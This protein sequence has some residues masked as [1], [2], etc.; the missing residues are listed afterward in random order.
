MAAATWPG[1]SD[2][3]FEFCRDIVDATADLVC[4]VQASGG[5]LRGPS[6]PKSSWKR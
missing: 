3:M 6:P 5:L 1:R 4:A 2:A